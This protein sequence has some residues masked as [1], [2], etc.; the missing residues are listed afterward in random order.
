MKLRGWHIVIIYALSI[1]VLAAGLMRVVDVVRDDRDGPPRPATAAALAPMPFPT[2]LTP[3]GSIDR[4]SIGAPLPLTV[5]AFGADPIA[6]VVL[7]DGARIVARTDLATPASTATVTYPPLSV[8]PHLLHAEVVSTGDQTAATAPVT[9]TVQPGVGSTPLPVTV[10]AVPGETPAQVADRLD[11]D[12]AAITVVDPAAPDATPDPAAPVPAGAVVTAN[13]A[14]DA[15]TDTLGSDKPVVVAPAA[16]PSSGGAGGSGGTAAPTIEATGECTVTVTHQDAA[17]PEDRSSWPVGGTIAEQSTGTAGWVAVDGTKPIALTPGTHVFRYVNGATISPPVAVTSPGGCAKT[18]GW[19]GDVSISNGIVTSAFNGNGY[20]LLGQ[21]GDT[22]TRIPAAGLMSIKPGLSIAGELPALGGRD[23]DV[24]VWSFQGDITIQKAAGHLTVSDGVELADVIGQPSALTVALTNDAD[25]FDK[26]FT[27]DGKPFDLTWHAASNRTTKIRWQVTTGPQDSHLARLDPPGLLASGT[28]T[29]NAQ[30]N[31][32]A[33]G[34]FTV[35]LAAIP[36]T[37]SVGGGTVSSS[38]GPIALG[39]SP[40]ITAATLAGSKPVVATPAD[41]KVASA[42]IVPLPV[43]GTNVYLRIV[44][45]PDD[46]T[47]GG[48]VAAS[49]PLPL[50]LPRAEGAGDAIRVKVT[51]SSLDLGRAPNPALAGCAQVD[52][53]W[54]RPTGDVTDEQSPE[55]EAAAKATGNPFAAR[56]LAAFYPAD[57]VYCPGDWP[58][59]E[60]CS[61]VFCDAYYGVVDGLSFLW[62]LVSTY[63]DLAA[64]L[65]NT[66]VDG[67]VSTIGDMNVFCE[68]AGS[69]KA[70]CYA[71]SKMVA[72]VAAS[73]A[74]SMLGL[75]PRIPSSDVVAGIA[76]GEVGGIVSGFLQSIGVPCQE[77]A[78]D[79][80]AV[81][82]ITALAAKLG[83]SETDVAAQIAKD[84][85]GALSDLLVSAAVGAVKSSASSGVAA[86]SG[87]PFD[88]SIKGLYLTPAVEGVPQPARV[89][90]TFEPVS[91][92]AD[93]SGFA[94]MVAVHAGPAAGPTPPG[95]IEVYRYPNPYQP[96]RFFVDATR[97]GAGALQPNTMN[98]NLANDLAKLGSLTVSLSPFAPTGC[99]FDTSTVTGT[100]DPPL[101]RPPIGP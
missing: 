50:P 55:F 39:T 101:P 100:I 27:I 24:Q 2:T 36:T 32:G 52:V 6:S 3:V 74:L 4:T 68:L 21:Q 12:P 95:I 17:P 73:A 63:W 67:V 35:D 97:S 5:A 78:S 14:P 85:C 59:P 64:S 62:E 26:A 71:A 77:L 46:G 43:P 93:M 44:A 56:V 40:A 15:G 45:E 57:G 23:L 87:M 8:G 7:R 88:P 76:Q 34:R 72:G 65:Y 19:T 58:P 98:P 90:A 80:D 22:W 13:V 29:G 31:G 91:A 96:N 33:G 47:S 89:T 28:A 86:A 38:L 92:N 79:P 42:S 16:E 70:K 1:A 41:P 20:L 53:P 69:A 94:C 66:I 37:A 9:V 30:S 11:V 61:N 60:R 99:S 54:P 25:R 84:P 48:T 18:A 51:A 81:D 49:P 82:A 83:V 10:D 75:P